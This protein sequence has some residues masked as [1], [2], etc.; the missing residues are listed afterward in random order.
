MA[1]GALAILLLLAPVFGFTSWG[2]TF[3]CT[4]IL[5]I[6]AIFALDY[7]IHKSINKMEAPSAFLMHMLFL[8]MAIHFL[9]AVIY[10]FTA[11]PAGYLSDL[12]NNALNFRD[13]FYFSGVTLFTVGYG[14]IVPMGDFRFTATI[15]IYLGHFLIFTIV[16]WGLA[17]FSNRR[18]SA[19]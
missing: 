6:V 12:Q 14:D 2:L 1:Y 8:V 11:T 10:Y 13:A 7:L 3:A 16:A 17:H 19:R 18:S 9:F 4:A 15:Q 5:A